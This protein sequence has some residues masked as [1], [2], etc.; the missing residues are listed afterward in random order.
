[1]RASVRGLSRPMLAISLLGVFFASLLLSNRRFPG[2]Q[3]QAGTL[4]VSTVKVL[5]GMTVG[6]KCAA[7]AKELVQDWGQER[8][9]FMFFVYDGSDWSEIAKRKNVQI[10]HN[11]ELKMWHYKEYVTPDVVSK[12]DYFFLVDCDV[13]LKPFDVNQFLGILKHYSIPVA[14][15]S[16]EWG[17]VRDRSSDHRVCRSHPSTHHGRWVSFIECGPFVAF[18]AKAWSC[19]YPLV[20]GDLGSGWGL[21]YKWCEYAKRH[22][23]QLAAHDGPLGTYNNGGRMC[24]VIDA[25]SVEH[26]DEKTATARLGDS[27]QPRN[28]VY[29]FDAR[30]PDIPN[31]HNTNLLCACDWQ[32]PRWLATVYN[33]LLRGL[34]FVFGTWSWIQCECRF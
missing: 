9:D 34:A 5:V 3:I 33:T 23:P 32:W 28:D 4:D 8:F 12:Y 1:M 2:P 22:C 19:I 15:P 17:D 27:Y 30:F 26:L 16:V 14:Q 25:T 24:A 7:R 11:K 6:A 31:S 21:D 13:G 20:Q 10:F 18:K 29:E